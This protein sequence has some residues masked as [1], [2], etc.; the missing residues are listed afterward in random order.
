MEGY[1]NQL[2]VPNYC[3]AAYFCRERKKRGGACI[4]A[5][6][7]IQW[8]ELPKFS[9][10]S[11]SGVFECCAIELTHY[12]I[13]VICIYRVPNVNNLNYCLEK[14][15][16]I[17][18]EIS[19]ARYKNV[20]IAGDFNIDMLKKNNHTNA[21]EYLLMR[22]NLKLALKQPTRMASM[23]C[24][25]NFAHNFSKP[26][27]TDVLEFALSD[28]TAQ[29]L[30]CPVQTKCIVNFWY[31]AKRDY[32]VENIAKFKGHIKNLTFSEIYET[33]DPNIAYSNFIDSFK[34]LYDLCFPIKLIKI[35]VLKKPKWL[36]KGIKL[37]SQRKRKLLWQMRLNLS[38]DS[39]N[40]FTNY[41]KLHKK[42]IHLTQK[43]QNNHKIKQSKNKSKTTW[44]IINRAKHNLPKQN[45]YKI[46]V[47][48]GI[49]SNPKTI[50]EA[51]NNYFIDKIQPKLN[52]TKK[53]EHCKIRTSTKSM[54]MLPSVPL[55]IHKI[56]M[57]LNN[58][59]SVGYDGIST[60]I[61]KHVSMEICGHL[62]HI[63]NLC[64]SAGIFP[65]A[66]K[67]SI[68]KPMFKKENR[69][70]M[71]YYRPVALIPV[72]SK[73]FEKY[74]YKELYKFI[75]K[76]NILCDEQKGFRQ[77]RTINM[78]IYDFIYNVIQNVDKRIPVCGIFCDMTQ[79]FDHVD[80]AILLRKLEA[81]GIRGNLLSLLESYLKDR[82]QI[83]E[84]CQINPVTKREDIFRSSERKV[85][86]GVPQGSVL[87]PFVFI[88]YINDL[89]EYIE[90]PIT[91][92]ADDSTVTI[93]CENEE[94]YERDINNC[95][96]NVVNWL[97]ENNLKI[98]LEKTKVI[99]FS[100]RIPRICPNIH[101]NNEVVEEVESTKF[102]GLV[103]DKNLNWKAHTD[104]L[105]KRISKSAYALRSLS[106]VIYIDALLTAYYGI[107]ESH[108]RYAIIFWGNSTERETVFKAQK[109]CLRAMF[110]LKSTDSC[111]P[112]FK[113]HKILTL[114][115]LYIMEVAVFVKSNPNRF[116]LLADVVPRN[117]RDNN[118]VCSHPAKTALMS[119]SVY[120]MASVIYNKLPKQ[121]RELPL[122]LFKSRLRK[123]LT[124]K[125]YYTV[126]EFLTE[127]DFS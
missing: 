74:I 122:S 36:S 127:K 26:C 89:P 112:Y 32:S 44:E 106:P 54:F 24:I 41:S 96:K 9:N 80:Y 15:E 123:F 1:Q 5:R 109:R 105:C 13:I 38:R 27:K 53:P 97:E 58:T 104:T 120:C 75:D 91:L 10:L 93:P 81:Y 98:N 43:A 48:E 52:D 86:F 103:I 108:L 16:V 102:L 94:T 21:F 78:A 45:I 14:L 31:A 83:T 62:S 57:S 56:I 115:C 64:I 55:E 90:Q 12:R 100:Q 51:F 49:L 50:A 87:G 11:C 70:L 66:L 88:I 33:D 126:S 22:Y 30:H 71:K 63:I 117:R 119:K 76:N 40:K 69:E 18:R 59:S 46:K 92:F 6:N 121:W 37:C 42:I 34:L 99:N 47:K 124:H 23:T 20:V 77:H 72:I 61:L 95:L 17:L 79:A 84:I 35:N 25:D 116:K 7:D 125:V 111:M 113:Q 8:K 60:K 68:I 39:K 107:V 85:M 118:L 4:L 101:Y 19:L 67:T 73:I 29:L 114:P 28:H 82:K 2:Y 110:K 65:D 3:L